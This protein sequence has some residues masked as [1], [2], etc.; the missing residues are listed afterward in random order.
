MNSL[1]RN[2]SSS[3]APSLFDEVLQAF[4]LAI[5]G[6]ERERRVALAGPL[7][8]ELEAPQSPSHGGAVRGW[9]GSGPC[10]SLHVSWLK[11]APT[12]KSLSKAAS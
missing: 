4:Q 11:L 1:S 9:A 7:L 12:R 2:V 3:L 5:P 10:C 8:N 6:G